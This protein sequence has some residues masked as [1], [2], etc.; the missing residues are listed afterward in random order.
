MK[1]HGPEETELHVYA[2]TKYIAL[3]QYSLTSLTGVRCDVSLWLWFASPSWLVLWRIF[4]FT[5]WPFS[6]FVHFKLG[7]LFLFF[8]LASC[9]FLIYSRHQILIRY[10]LLRHLLPHSAGCL[11]NF[12]I[13]SFAVQRPFGVTWSHLFIS[14]L[15]PLLLTSNSKTS[16]QDQYQGAYHLCFLLE[17]KPH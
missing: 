17:V 8:T 6:T 2:V 5:C 10:V 3:R 14:L 15:S 9:E 16:C 13:L 12:L 11:F 1:E 7:S 4:S